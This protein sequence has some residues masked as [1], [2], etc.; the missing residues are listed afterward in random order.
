MTEAHY[1]NTATAQEPPGCLVQFELQGLKGLKS[2]LLN[3]HFYIK[4]VHAVEE[5]TLSCYPTVW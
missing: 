5:D 1:S 4:N 3:I 2:R